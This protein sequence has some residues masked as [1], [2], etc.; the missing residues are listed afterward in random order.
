MPHTFETARDGRVLTVLLD[1]PP[2]NLIDRRMVAELTTLVR[3]L[4]RDRSLGSLVVTGKPD[5]LF[6][7]HYDMGEMLAG[8]ARFRVTMPR[9]ASGLAFWASIGAARIPGARAALLRTPV[10]GIL[11]LHAIVTLLRRIERLDKVV[12]AAINGPALGAACELA[13][14]C[15]LRY[16]AADAGAIGSP[17]LSQGFLP[18]AGGTQRYARALRPARALE[19][20]LEARMPAP[21]EALALG[22]VHGILPPEQLLAKAVQTAHRLARRTPISIAAAKRAVYGGGRLDASLALGRRW[23]LAAL[24][25]PAAR[26]AM[27]R[28]VDDLEREGWGPWENESTYAPWREGTA[29]DLLSA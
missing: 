20:L 23:F 13:L 26:H 22:L 25:R 18:G 2:H 16:M 12:I 5:G 15:D 8:S 24:S 19:H 1:N 4:E 10:V 29:V 9:A 27:R 21:E 3:A 14:T 7:T 6:V 17:E 11:D 28:Y